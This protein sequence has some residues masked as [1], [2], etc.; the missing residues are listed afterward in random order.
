MA[1]IFRINA[2]LSGF[3]GAP[4]VN[5]WYWVRSV[6]IGDLSPTQ[7]G[8]AANAMRAFYNALLTQYPQDVK[9]TVE[10]FATVL[11]STDG[12][13]RDLVGTS[14]APAV[15]SGGGAGS[16]TSRATQMC[17]N[18]RTAV[19]VRRRLLRGRMFLGPLDNGA[20]SDTGA[21]QA[22]SATGTISAYGANILNLVEV[23][24]VV[25]SRPVF[26]KR[27]D[28]DD[29]LVVKEPGQVG[30]VESVDVKPLPAVLRSRRQ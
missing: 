27:T 13:V 3:T 2:A 26:Q 28:P 22:G 25:W 8:L 16:Q 19:P 7:V 24:H 17:L 14:P 6:G 21:I 18:L 9:I 10:P 29:P 23:K 15:V 5:S 4:G 11:E 1:S 30:Q 12:S 20:I